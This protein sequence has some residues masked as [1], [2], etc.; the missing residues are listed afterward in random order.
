MLVAIA[1]I[2]LAVGIAA[3][4]YRAVTGMPPEPPSHATR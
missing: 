2:V 4:T 3:F 1:T